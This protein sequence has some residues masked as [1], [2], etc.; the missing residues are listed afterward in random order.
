L[1]ANP[2]Q[3]G[4]SLLKITISEIA[5]LANVSKS[6]VSLVINKK[7]GV[8]AKTR[9]KVLRIIEKYNYNPNEIARSLAGR[10]TRSIGLVIKEI[11]NPYFARL[12]RGVYDACLQLGYLVLLGSSEHLPEKEAETIKT[13]ISKRVD[14]IIISPL[15][16]EDFDFSSFPDLLQEKFPLVVLG[17]VSNSTIR[18]VDIDNLKAA[19]DAATYL[20]QKGHRRIAHL[21]GPTAHGRIRMEGYKQ[22]LL[23]HN[24]PIERSLIGHVEP[25]VSSG[26]KV[27]KAMFAGNPEPPTAVFCYNDLVA[28]GLMNALHELEIDVPGSVS[29]MGF[30]NIE[31]DNYL[32]IP[33]TTIEMPAYE[34]GMAAAKLLIRHIGARSSNHVE[35]IILE[36]RIVER[37]S[38]AKRTTVAPPPAIAKT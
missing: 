33:L 27:G 12:I 22:A 8:S 30:D 20:I 32:R 14:G 17:T 31:I 29:I 38:V 11:D 5:K 4:D 26:Y 23:D 1:P 2:I 35:R 34:I 3:T 19:Y 21:A 25:S 15:Q 6:S 36:H 16:R 10:E 13:L 18:I 24:I 37:E 9:E 28:I 7:A